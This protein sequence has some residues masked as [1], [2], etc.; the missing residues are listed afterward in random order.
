MCQKKTQFNTLALF[1]LI[2]GCSSPLSGPQTKLDQPEGSTVIVDEE[3]KQT[4]QNTH[5]EFPIE[6]TTQ[7][8]ESL[9]HR[10]EELE[11]LAPA[12]SRDGWDANLG[13]NLLREPSSSNTLALDAAVL[14]ALEN[15]ID[16]KV[17]IL[18]PQIQEQS[19]V[20]A[21]AAFDFLF[22]A[23]AS[24][25][26][27]KTPQQQATV[28][29]VPINSSES[30]VDTLN[31]NL[32]FA[33][34]LYGGGTLTLSTDAIK[35]DNRTAGS[36]FLPDPAWQTVGTID[37]SQPLLRNFGEP[38]TRAQI[39]L[40]NI[41]RTQSEEELKTTL[42]KIITSTTHA[43]LDLSLQW[44]TLQVKEWL[45]Q[46]GEEV[47]RILDIRR[48]YDA[49]EADYAQAVATVQQR[50]A[51][52]ISQ[53]SLVQKAS[54]TLKT[55]INTNEYPLESET[56]IQPNSDV[57]ATPISI[58]LR[59]A[60]MTALEHRPDLRKLK[61]SIDSELINVE[62]AD[63]A[64]LPKLDMQAQL[65]FRGLGESASD[66]YQ[67]VFDTDF[68]N[69][70]A[71]LTFE[72]PL[73]NRAAEANYTSA[74]LQKMSAESTYKQGV[75]N[76]IV[77]VKTALR[78]IVT[79]AELIQANKAFRIAQTENLRALSVEEE[80]MA[81]LSPTF[82]NLKLQTQAGL[83]NARIAEFG[84]IVNYNKSIASLYEAMGTTLQ[85]HQIDF[86]TKL[87]PVE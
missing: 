61:L 15:N 36:V 31:G 62:V 9:L 55:Y 87:P 35:T 52:M 65:S 25:N 60:I 73:G 68:I 80:T 6:G 67:E 14:L 29:G 51:D 7:V 30:T 86:E 28:G 11:L 54:D 66:G 27:S 43:Y 71:G 74:R 1:L 72:I 75:Q 12:N 59:Q 20:E 82:L 46:Q 37:L 53:Q 2:Q 84:A 21:E 64:R 18:Q 22:G 63:N 26:R 48:Q 33:K 8:E 13:T 78:D 77:E 57:H 85:M 41:A 40:S 44:K 10:M 56:T 76:T 17:A 16:I 5:V 47:V 58:S 39:R 50:R 81:G 23:G 4:I 42:N 83:S 38:V 69:Y 79:N 19:V 3:A 70:L 49:A 24:S 45:L 34:Q 32:S